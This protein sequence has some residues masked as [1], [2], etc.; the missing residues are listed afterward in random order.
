MQFLSENVFLIKRYIAEETEICL[1]RLCLLSFKYLPVKS[2]RSP[3][4][5]LSL[6]SCFFKEF[7]ASFLY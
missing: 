4:N 1:L 6:L 7:F 5:D 3:A 2:A